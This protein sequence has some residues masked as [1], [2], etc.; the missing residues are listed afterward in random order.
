MI[1]LFYFLFHA[2]IFIHCNWKS[3]KVLT[4]EVSRRRLRTLAKKIDD[5]CALTAWISLFFLS[6][7]TIRYTSITH[8]WTQLGRIF[9]FFFFSLSL[10]AVVEWSS[11]IQVLRSIEFF[12][13]NYLIGP[14]FL[15]R[16][17][18][19]WILSGGFVERNRFLT[20]R[21]I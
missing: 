15:I 12:L 18:R 2:W 20:I 16:R 14:L 9:L 10:A 5:R 8:S 4:S 17:E 11:N 6:C 21:L 7:I 13:L 3:G 1:S 19:D